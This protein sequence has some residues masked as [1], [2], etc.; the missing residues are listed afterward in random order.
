MIRSFKDK[1]TAKV[2]A[3]TAS[4]KLPADI[5]RRAYMKLALL[6]A[7]SCIEVMKDPPSNHL[8]RLKGVRSGEWSIRIN[9][10]WRIVFKY[11]ENE[12]NFYNVGI[13]D[14]H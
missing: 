5:H 8:E 7:A 13:E 10:Q 3:M 12:K 6:N 2:F 9:A 1:E 14:Y 4:R 11:D